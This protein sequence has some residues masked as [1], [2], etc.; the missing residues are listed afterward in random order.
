MFMQVIQG[1]VRDAE[2]LRRAAEEWRRDLQPGATGFLGSTM[3]VT[4]DGTGVVV[5]RFES[6]AAAQANSQRPEQGAWWERTKGLFDGDV[7]FTDCPDC[8]VMLDGGSDDA[9]FVQLISARA[10]DR[11]AMRS[12]GQD[13]EIDLRESRPDI[14]GGIVGWSGG[15]EFVQVMYFAD[16]ERARAGEQAMA[17]NPRLAEWGDMLEG[18]PTFLDLRD[19]TYA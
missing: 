15:T 17:D 12:A 5:A 8:D 7:S 10:K 14:I 9:G 1:R 4:P 18:P 2:G 13:L 11:D 6:E 19:P 16:E 3:G